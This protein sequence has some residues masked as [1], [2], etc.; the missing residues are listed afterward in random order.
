ML[1]A[2]ILFEKISGLGRKFGGGKINLEDINNGVKKALKEFPVEEIPE[3]ER[4]R[5]ELKVRKKE[6]YDKEV[7]A[8]NSQVNHHISFLGVIAI[9]GRFL[10][11]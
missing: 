2:E 11:Q 9:N 6:E 5:R 7:S 3:L 8:I 1:T 4:M 10:R